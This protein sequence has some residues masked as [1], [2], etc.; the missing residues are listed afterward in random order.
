MTA[1][2]DATAPALDV[3]VPVGINLAPFTAAA[4]SLPK[5]APATFTFPQ[6]V[7]A[8]G[9][10]DTDE[11]KATIGAGGHVGRAGNAAPAVTVS[12]DTV[13]LTEG[14]VAAYKV[15]LSQVPAGLV[16]VTVTSRDTT[17]VHVWDEDSGTWAAATTLEF[18]AAKWA[19]QEVQV[20]ARHDPDAADETVSIGHTAT[21]E[22]DE[23]YS[24]LTGP[25]VVAAVTDDDNAGIDVCYG[26]PCSTMLS[27]DEGRTARY[28]I[29]LETAPVADVTVTITS[30][31]PAVTVATGGGTQASSTT[32]Q[33]SPT[34]Y[35]RRQYITVRAEEDGNG[36]DETVRLSHVVTT[37]SSRDY[38]GVTGADMVVK[39]RDTTAPTLTI[40]GVPAAINSTDPFTATFTFSEDVTGFEKG[41]VA[42]TGG[43]K[44]AFA[45][46]GSSY[47][48]AVTPAGGGAD[49]T[50][51]VRA[52]A[53]TD[54]ESNAG[55]ATAVSK[56]A[57]W[58]ATAP[59][60]TIGGVP[61]GI[62]STDPFTATFTFSEKVTGFEKGDVTVT[63]GTEG[64]FGGDGSSYTLVVTPAGGGADVTVSVGMNA[65][66]DGAGNAGPATAVSKTAA[67][68]AT[69][70]TLTISGVP[71]TINSTDPFTATFTFSEDVTGFEKGDV[72]VTGGTKGAFGGDGSSYTLVVTP[73]GNGA[74]V[75]VSVGMNAAEDGAGN[76]G[77]ATAASKTAKWEATPLT[78]TISG[79]PATINSTDPF[80]ATFTF[81][82][83]VTGFEKGDVTVTGG[84]KGAFG[85][86][87]SSYTLAVTP[88]GNGADVTVTV[89]ANAATYGGGSAGPATAA[90]K[91]AKWDAAPTLMIGGVPAA[92][93][94]ASAFT[95]TFTFSEDVTGFEKGDVAVTGGTKGAFTGNGADY[96]LAVTPSGT[97]DV[98]VT[99]EA[100]AATDGGGNAG[101]VTAVS[102]TAAW[103]ATA[104]TLEIGVPAGINSM[105]AF[106][107][108]FTF[109]EDVTG[110]ETD[111]VAVL[112]GT[113]GTF[114]GSRSSYTLVVTPL[115]EGEDVDVAVYADAA[116]D[117]AGNTGPAQL[118]E[119]KAKWD[120]TAPT[121]EIGV[122]AGINSTDPFTARFTF[123]ETVTGFETDDV[124]VLGGTK[125]T[126]TGSGSGYTLVVTPLAEGEDVDVA[127]YADAAMDG[128][129]NTG[130]AQLVEAKAKWD[131]T[132]P[133][134]TISGVPAGINSTSAFTARF[135]FS[136]DV[137]GFEKGDV[138]VTGGTKGRFRGSG[139][140]YTLRVTPAGSGA[141]V[142]VTVRANA[143]TDG[144]GNAGPATAVSKTAAWDATAP[145]LTISGVPATINSTD[146][147]TARFTFSEDVRGFEKGD[148]TVTGGTKGRF[149]GSGSS[150][151]LR[152]T[153]SGNGADVKVS[154]GMN[155]ARD[156]AG[157]TGPAAASSATAAWEATPLTLTIGG[158]PAAINS[159]SAFTARF[160]FSEDVT[161]F[162]KGDVAVTGGTKGAFAGDGSS[163]TLAVTPAGSGADVTVTV[164]A[165]AATDGGG[166]AGP[167]TAV[168]KTAAWDATAPTLTIGGVP[169]AI[170]STDEF[171]ARFT[172][173][174]DVTG[175]EKGDV[176][177][178]GGTKGAFAG[179]RSS[180][181]LVVTPDSA[182]DVKVEVRANAATDG[183]GNAGPATAVS[184][185]AAW[186][187]TAPTLTISGV[188]ATIN[189]TSAFT[190][191]FT[192]SED[193]T[194]FE[195]GDVTVTGGTKGAFGG[196][197][198]S[199]TL[200]VTPAGNGADVRVSVGM[201]A[202]ED[203]AGNQGPATAAS[204]TAKWEATPLT[205]TISGVPATIN[206][207]SA[208]TARFTFS[209]DVTGFEKGDVTVTGGTKGAFGGDGS[210]YTLAVTPAG[211][212]ADVT[213][214]VR[215]NAATYGGGSAG[216]ATAASKTAKWD[217]APTLTIGGV[218]AATN[219]TSAFTA[220]FTFSED[221]TGFEKDDVA[222]T[223]GT[224]GAFTGNGADYTLAVTPSGTGDVTVT[225]EA[226]AATDGGGN[227]GPVTAVSKT[228]AWDA[229]APTLEIGVPAGI[230]SMS[231]F[232]ARFTFSEDVTG[233]EKGDVTVTGGTK[234][235]FTG[236]R[237]SYTLVVTPDSAA[238]V[239]VEVRANAA[240]DGAGNAGPA[241][242]VSKTAAWDATAPT[243]TISGVPATIN[244]TDEFTATFTFSEDVT[245]FEKGD[246]TV[247]GGTKGA[248]TGSRSSYTLVV[249][250]DSAADVKVEVRANA[251]TDGA[252]NAG[253]AQAVSK[254]A[255]WDATA[256]TLTI[257]GVPATINSTDEFTAR[258]T[259]S[260]DVT[261]FEKGDV[262]VTGG[263]KGAFAGDGS[264]YTLAVTPAG[265]GADVTVSVGMNA[266]E[267]GAGNQGPATAVSKTAKWDAAP[268]L[269]I[270]GVPAAINS[271]DEFTARF[272]FS[273]DVT[274]FEKG[275]VAVT[276]GTK[277]AFTGNGADYTLA[278]TPAGSGADVT[279]TVRAN[280][281]TD[282]GGNAGP[283]TA[284]SKTAAWDATAP[285][286]TIGGV[287][288]AINS[289]D[290]FTARFTFSE[291]VTG[292]EKGD[293]TV[294]G[295]T[296][297]AFAG[298]RSS[299]TLVVTPDSAADVKVEVRANAATDGAGN[300]GPA[301]AVSK[302]AAWDATAPTLTISGV[303]AT[304]NSTDP[305]TAT[306]TFS[307]D[308]TGFEKGDVTVT[309]GTKG[310]FGGDGSSY[311]LVVTPAGNGADVTVA[312]RKDAAEDGAGNAGPAQAVSRT[313]SN[314][315][316]VTV[317]RDTLK[318]K[319]ASSGAY[320]VGLS[321][322][323]S[324]AVT[325][326]VT[327]GDTTAVKVANAGGILGE[328]TT[329]EFTA[330]QWMRQR[331][332]VVAF[333]DLD[334]ADETVSIG[335]RATSAADASYR[336]L[337]GPSLVVTVADPDTAAVEVC[338]GNG[339]STT[340]SVDEGRTA[341][342]A[343]SLKAQPVAEVTV[344]VASPDP[345]VTV[346]TG[347][348]AQASTATLK[349]SAG[350]Y[351]VQYVTVRAA[352]D[353][354][355][356][357]ETVR[358]SHAASGSSRDYDGLA[359]AD[360]VVNVSDTTSLGLQIGGVPAAINST[361]AF[362]ATFTFSEDVTGFEKG[363]VTVTGGTKGAFAGDGSSYTLAVTPAGSGADVTVTVR[364][365]AA[366][367]GGGNAGPATAV[368]KT[369]AWDAT[370]PT[371]TI[372][373]VP[374]TIN[375][376]DPF[377][378]TFTF[379]EK[380]TGF[381]KG[382]VTVTG[383]TEGAFG[384]DGSS[385]TLAVTPDSAADVKVEVR[386][387]AATDGAGNAGPA[388][389]VSKTAA[390]DATAPTLTIGGVPAAV[391]STDEFTATFTFSEDVTGFDTDD[392]TVTRGA[393]G[394]FAGDGSSYTLRVTPSGTG[395]V[396]VTVRANAATDG[397]GNTSPAQA[398]SKT[399]KNPIRVLV[400]R[401][402]LKLEE[403][404]TRRGSYYYVRLTRA[405]S[406]P[407][408]VTATSSDPTALSLGRLGRATATLLFTPA[409]WQFAASMLVVARNDF[410]AADETVSIGHRA[411]SAADASYR[412]IAGPSLVV[413][414][415]DPDTAAVELCYGN[416]CSTTL[417][418]NEGSTADYAVW[419]KAEPVDEVTVT[420]TSP[421]PAVTV[422]T[423]DG[424]Q[425][426]T[427]TLKFSAG[428]YYRR[429]SVTVRAAEDGNGV[430]ET[431]RLSHAASG[432][433]RDYDGLAG[434]DM[435]V[436]VSDTTSLG[437]QIGGV[438]AAINSTSAFTATFTFSEDVTGFDT[439]DVTVTGGTKGAF[440]GSGADYTLA[441]TPA[442]N[443]ADV[444]VAVRANAATDGAGNAAP[445]TAA[446]KTAAW[447]ATAPTLETGVPNEVV[448]V[449]AF[450]ATFAF[451]EDVT[452][453]ETGDV[454]V[455]GGTKGAFAGKG[456][457]YTL[458]VTPDSAVDVKVE[459]RKDAA[460]DA[461][462]NTGPAQAVSATALKDAT[463]PTLT[464]GGVPAA[465]N[466]T[467]E[468]TATFTFS[469]DVTGFETGDV[470]VTGG[471][472]GAFA[473][474]GADYTLAV[475]PDS[476]VDVKVEVRKDAARDAAG[477][478][479]PAQAVSA[480]ALKDVTAPTL[481]IG[482]P[483]V[484]NSTDEF[485][486][487]FAFSE[488][489]TGF[490]TGDVTVTGGTK[491]A[492]AGDG[493]S[494]TL[495][496]TPSGTGDV[497]V[498]VEANAAT[499][500]VGN[501]G[502]AQTA[503]A[504]AAW[505]ATAPT[506]TISGVPDTINSMAAFTAT[507]TFSE[508]VSVAPWLVT[509]T[510][511]TKGAFGGDG[512]SYT[513]AVTPSGTG[514]VTVTVAANAANDG[515][516]NTG[517]AQ[518]VSKTATN[519][520]RV[521]VSLDSLKVKEGRTDSYDVGLTRAPSGPVTVTVT[522]GDATAA[523]V[524][525]AGVWGETTTLEFTAEQWVP[526]RVNVAAEIDSDA[527][528]ET[529]SIRHVA[530][531]EVD[532]NYRNL[533]G[534]SLDVTVADR[535][536]AA[537]LLCYDS[538]CSTTLSVDE[539]H[540][541]TYSVML[542]AEPVADV[543][544]TITSPDPA[545][546]VATGDST[547]GSSATL[548]FSSANYRWQSVTVRAEED[549]N[550]FDET[551]RLSH[552]ATG[553]SRD[554]DGLKG[555]DMVVNVK[556]ATP[557]GMDIGVPAGINSTAPFTA[558]FAFSEPVTGFDTDDV[559]VTGGTKGA[560]GG[561]GAS[562]T[563]EVTPSGTGNVT[564]AVRAEAATDG[565]ANTVPA[566]AASATARWDATAPALR[567]GV[568][569]GVNS[570]AFTAT[571]AFS[572][573]VTGFDTD[574]VTVAG[575]TKGAFGGSGV[576]Y[577]LEVTPSGTGADVTVAV[578][579]GAA[580]DAV[581][582]AGPAEAVSATAVW[583]ATTPTL[584][585]GVPAEVV[586]T[587]PFTA[588]FVFSEPVKGFGPEDVTVTRGTKGTFGGS[589]SSYTLVVTP[590][591][592]GAVT[593]EV[594]AGAAVDVAGNAGPA[595][596]VSATAAWDATAP[597]LEIGVPAEVVGT[598]PF[599]A[600]LTFSEPVTGFD[601][602]D[603]TVTG[604]TKGAFTGSGAD[605]TLVVTPSAG[606]DVVV[607]VG[608]HAAEDVAGN[609]GPAQAASATAAW[610]ATAPTLEIVVP[611]VIDSAFTA[612]F[613]FSEPVGGF[614]ADDVTVTGGTKGAFTGSGAD[615]TLEVT[616]WGTGDDV[617]IEVEGGAAVDGAGHA[618]PAQAVSATAAWDATA[619][620]LEIGVPDEVVGV[621]AFTATFA[622]SE[623]VS[624]FGTEDVTVTG[625]TKGAFGGRGASYTLEVTPFRSVDVTLLVEEAAASAAGNAAPVVA[626]STMVLRDT[627][628][629]T[630]TITA[631]TAIRSASTFTATF[632]FSEPVT[633]FGAEDVTVIGGTKG[634][635][636]GTR[637]SYT[638]VVTPEEGV[639]VTVAVRADALEDG[640]GNAGPEAA[641]SAT[642][643]WDTT[644]PTLE[645]AV[646]DEVVGVEAFTATF[647]FSE[648]VSGFDADDVTVTGGTKG[649]FTG[650]GADYTL[651]V[652]PSGTG[653]VTLAVRKDAAT[654]GA[655]NAGPAQE[656]S[657]MALKDA[658]APTLEMG[659]P[660][661]VV[662]VE[663]FTATFAFSEP[664][665][666][667]DADDVTVT[668]GTKGAFTGN[669]SS[670]TLAVTPS[671]TG[672]VTLAVRKD[673]ATD[674]A[675]NA[676]PAQE[677]SAMALKDATAP[678]P[679]I[680]G[681]PAAI[682]STAPFTAT[683][684]FSEPVEGFDADDVTVTG[685]TKGTFGGRGS[686]YTLE[687]TP[688]GNGDVTVSVP[689]D[690]ATDGAGNAG[691][692][693]EVSATAAW[694]AT[695]PTL[696]IGVPD[697]VVGVEA[698]TVTFAF[699]EPVTGFDTDD[700]TVTGGTKGAFT[701]NG[702]S[703]TLEVTPSGN[704]DVT[705]SVR[706]DAATDGVGHTGPAV[707]AS[708][709]AANPVRVMVS[710]D[711]LKLKEDDIANYNVGLSR[712]PAG[713]VTVTVTS[714]DPTAVS[715]W[716]DGT[717]AATTT[718][719]FTAAQWAP[720]PVD[721]LVRIGAHGTV[722]I[723][724]MATSAADANYRNLR[725]P[726]VVV[727]VTGRDTV[728]VDACYGTDCSTTLS[729]DKGRTA[730]DDVGVAAVNG[731][732]EA[733][734]A[735]PERAFEEGGAAAALDLASYFADRDGDALRY[736]AASSDPAVVAVSV[737]GA[738]LTMTPAGYGSASVE[739][740]AHDPGGLE[741]RQVFAVRVSDRMARAALDETLAAT[742]RAHLASARMTLGRRVGPEGGEDR[743]RLTLMGRAV[744]LNGATVREAANR[745]LDS[746]AVARYLRGGGLA[747]AGR[748]F[749]RRM[750]EWASAVAEDWRDS[751]GKPPAPP[752]LASVL[753]VDRL[754]GLGNLGD[755]D[756]DTEFM[757]AFGGKRGQ[758]AAEGRAWQFWGQGDL[759][760][761]A[762]KPTTERGFD[763][764]LRTGHVGID[765]ALGESWLA[766]VAVARSR[767][768]GDW[769]AGS[770]DGRLE[771]S[772]TAVHP[773][774]RWSDGTMSLW[775]MA[776]GGWGSAKNAR[777]TGRVGTSALDLRL[778]LFEARRE[779]APWFALRADAAWA[780]L[781]TGTGGETVD[782]RS[783]AVDQQR[784][785]I[786]LKPS[787]RLGG[788]AIEL[789]VEASARRD[790][791]VGQAGSGLELAGGL[792]AA[793]G[794]VRIGARG[795]FLALHSAQGYEERGLGVTLTVGSPAAEDGLSL[796]ISPSWGGPAATSGELWQ[797]VLSHRTPV[798]AAEREA[799]S[800]DAQ[801][802]YAL[803]LP[804]GR[805]LAWSAELGR[806]AEGYALTLGAGIEGG[807]IEV[808]GPQRP[809]PPR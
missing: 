423:G 123:S 711:T 104:P 413:T 358:L 716:K 766:G 7:E 740:M 573:P 246:V 474:D 637:S 160:T 136:E 105:S 315:V 235:A 757:F 76:Q 115:A 141:D 285:T 673:A 116:M 172:F 8:F 282:G 340:L 472:K 469:E 276:G 14:G 331:V 610:D 767:G 788:L 22:A 369:A 721:L 801:A 717:W 200:A 608:A 804:G 566:Q 683:F 155:A 83:D 574:D 447:D 755:R 657:A 480:T 392:V 311:T 427:A 655:G 302:T 296:K 356:V 399:A 21:S 129:G 628:A 776:G 253:P 643:A 713:P 386:A 415:A 800:L 165:N 534:P 703:Y 259:F 100:N 210:S 144:G 613:A 481:E 632:I 212:G 577:T 671:G 193:V 597:T 244:S 11:T 410:D 709:T 420:I 623:P 649:A 706:A 615:Y 501:A 391:N 130:P 674:G 636:A 689:A 45:G 571:F 372:G 102:K 179:S 718:L 545:V 330:A 169:A 417:S 603:V 359:G 680:T 84:T 506:V 13:D 576:D 43:T 52:N 617:T 390:W 406:G 103:D 538:G 224:K 564:V 558:T 152:V 213:V 807:I 289:T 33:I 188:P 700:V 409:N 227:A 753:G 122:P 318:M 428:D 559:T 248:F 756:G 587:S 120:A 684:A 552:A 174:E 80:T 4:A 539:G 519:P 518:A 809:D 329:L 126:F 263:T 95:A 720:R 389:A 768:A 204:K 270:G 512:S 612:A 705:V 301:T 252:G 381:E 58:D 31:N 565:A 151:T 254:T 108:R 532:D 150:Y 622:F 798:G 498:T 431:V 347:D 34:S 598:S 685:G 290:E 586:G 520:V 771:T 156:A 479:G 714:G 725:G 260:E 323:P 557:L 697:E 247:T 321:R 351:R 376:T 799:W 184:K 40:G 676:G 554:Y 578:Q 64:A 341:D 677:A 186:D 6:T 568:P 647:A 670:Y 549:G 225:V 117:G 758:E 787:M 348:G 641:A 177:V 395:D 693:Q 206:S 592:T 470:T 724:H 88:A 245:G 439:E 424:A 320:N 268:T 759:Q 739:V 222:V 669:G 37:G 60:L 678:T 324:G 300:A 257:S 343:V 535:D 182:A 412:N 524:S 228:A 368:S 769:R 41:D 443:G 149:R 658:T 630:L 32:V 448:G 44:G 147:F 16:T 214:T 560:F 663:A 748:E 702:S 723:G 292:F 775:A 221:V 555:A 772:L 789:I 119:A 373:G 640:A 355:G 199:Y 350:D 327:S 421:D 408:T 388:Q 68:D 293:V 197:G 561:G 762:G 159:T 118:V 505:D 12:R 397:A 93:N 543:T 537:I 154:V 2:W 140:S 121:L 274:G 631:P 457:D 316:R 450:T 53:A 473:G 582:N 112:G 39:V 135:T 593:V 625:G 365:N 497:T 806:S 746:W 15:G 215:A 400:S 110:F 142:T 111:D 425:A 583:D 251:A 127:V 261:G 595:T 707:E 728:A 137:T 572:E 621:Q 161:G 378:V 770:V 646:P 49:V 477:N 454:T 163:Y 661:E 10:D 398:V 679:E 202:A 131:V 71:A 461:V 791:G 618:G 795:R 437:L 38:R 297:G 651:A 546:T 216:P 217:A 500:G 90:S 308:V 627:T 528:D 779:F 138:T 92:I 205:L 580:E 773:Y 463:A 337:A 430:D 5:M 569:T 371:L 236:S 62:N 286:L 487:T 106:T 54:G 232:T 743:S 134:L 650:T 185:T 237:S 272:T 298:S 475:T 367:D 319:D 201:N 590:S 638:L 124:A 451:S 493:S 466:S 464:I 485:T 541:A 765:R 166:N 403:G 585:I 738:M 511:G 808:V 484:V 668:G 619:P 731:A 504:M 726:S 654:D 436:N 145:T 426:S 465:V 489:V 383:G 173:S 455:T 794:P 446:S 730:E 364:A 258:F 191:T 695:A 281:A 352:E 328:T 262:A 575:G 143:A 733:V 509:V 3:A 51:T 698:F 157:N 256:P 609:A 495:A 599:T 86:D 382:D 805:L 194:G 786:E 672:D 273:E 620:G 203:G 72:T 96:T 190:A 606:R 478:T 91:T 267:D 602:E 284:V 744:P 634:A 486:A 334:A 396:T 784:L 633:G 605:Y 732:P 195:K 790:G 208:F 332:N 346:A 785:G 441:V 78:L 433:S 490:E 264:S 704:G 230:N 687:V 797:E 692:A 411:T 745:L 55:P 238:D 209:E 579:K 483:P 269:T 764:D 607:G 727:T 29:R 442:G 778:G 283:A 28:N 187:A 401:D 48:L 686:S 701:G 796:S 802:R 363:D 375:S 349:F 503:S 56:T 540:Q 544:V 405:P 70:P 750:T 444:T 379:S 17:A 659:V 360:M 530:T 553:S 562:Y 325:V 310:A 46:D 266:V 47:T 508:K 471:T 453:F 416:G 353:G 125:G 180:Y 793:A 275:D 255:A 181:T 688:S 354:N 9:A 515:A 242:A 542:K 780:R 25:L 665:S 729:A 435:V 158:V 362:T 278:V 175:F 148:V 777:A 240:T 527:V 611:A 591:G 494:Y 198:S 418:V 694:D 681:V 432:S 196:D 178:T 385:Y 233:F 1:A 342:Y 624:G 589:G 139:S 50:V 414:V 752:D 482:V 459:V 249:T 370:A 513:L 19:S 529:V 648:P 596:T 277:G 660:D 629:P 523:E 737:A 288:A 107:A 533:A 101:P 280:A 61:A 18:T 345:A 488:D 23:G 81:S 556:D 614:G 751:P 675:G 74:D 712:A 594:G 525:H 761:F 407:V 496:V 176:T 171:T 114:T 462:G 741:A 584:E 312:V 742:G 57:A 747:E 734:R 492:F 85:G 570:A 133:T 229:T 682:N 304:I 30:P 531:S 517:P 600:E 326:T 664:V 69:A 567:I 667:F 77:P 306:F 476:A 653:D 82:E 35:L 317:S 241:Q 792:R 59:T 491:G 65:A 42:V 89:R 226:N 218:P 146:P 696:K 445:P 162:E 279:V 153:P 434:A 344:T 699:S 691:P 394:A 645:I 404:T 639:D 514:D 440:T 563:L 333:H 644:A 499:D 783:A 20:T 357:D 339:C 309:G 128:A 234:G 502:P 303:P 604:G 782:S 189:S 581:G 760:T 63:G 239:K 98:T 754:G 456:A 167:A 781:A 265:N 207:T 250:P 291:D 97:R 551:V 736:S 211:S 295:G 510:G 666:G 338:Y 99:V 393:K 322:A 763:G 374:A 774:L 73:A 79:V 307:E 719:E 336:N 588:T 183:A 708:A 377:T 536:T 521:T 132:A 314:P 735:I 526:Q 402:T 656:A 438:P 67:W 313:A 361:S 642:A 223:G 422:A 366:T 507:L 27:V 458:A 626:V 616:P 803:R 419:L 24:N 219:S 380:V 516:G 387:N 192:F 109:S 690:A 467:D 305:F 294:T 299:Y 547:P 113:K 87:G 26:R 66:E 449:E 710:R 231:A 635:F 550:G 452:G 384:G 94:S 335:H 164:R 287:P 220:T 460:Q 170:N 722:A 715:V 243:L 75:R 548:E 662:G 168:S 468:F 522:S 429:Q 652:T 601:A 36:V 271:T 749:E